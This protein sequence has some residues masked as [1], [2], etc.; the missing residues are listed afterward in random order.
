M[1]IVSTILR[2]LAHARRQREQGRTAV[3][4]VCRLD[5]LGRSVLE[6]ARS[7]EELRQLRIPIHSVNEGRLLP[8]LVGD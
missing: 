3:V 2:L 7:A 1:R 8:D 4:V 5:R 6:R